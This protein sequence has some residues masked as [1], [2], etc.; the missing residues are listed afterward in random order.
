MRSPTEL[1]EMMSARKEEEVKETA[2]RRTGSFSCCVSFQLGILKWERGLH[3][4]LSLSSFRKKA[5]IMH[6]RGF[7]ETIVFIGGQSGHLPHWTIKLTYRRWLCKPCPVVVR[8]DDQGGMLTT[9][10][11][12]LHATHATCY[13]L[14]VGSVSTVEL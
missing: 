6:T 14:V 4:R 10:E 13:V 9:G 1:H 8:V 3:V 7:N 5:L 11:E 12:Q 2:K